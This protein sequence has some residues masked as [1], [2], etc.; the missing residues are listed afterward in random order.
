MVTA[1]GL[2]GLATWDWVRVH[3]RPYLNL[4]TKKFSNLLQ[5]GPGTRSWELGGARPVN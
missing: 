2:L 1:C 4:G 5:L 3:V